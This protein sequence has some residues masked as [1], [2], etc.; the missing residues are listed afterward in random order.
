MRHLPAVFMCFTVLSRLLFWAFAQFTW[1]DALI[2][3]RYAENIF[4]GN[5][6]VYNLGEKVLGTT[7]PLYTFWLVLL[8]FL[9]GRFFMIF[10][11]LSNIQMDGITIFFLTKLLIEKFK[12]TT[13]ALF[14]TLLVSINPLLNAVAISGMEMSFLIMLMTLSIYSMYYEKYTLTGVLLGLILLTRMDGAIFLILI[15]VHTYLNCKKNSFRIFCAFILTVIPF[16]G[17]E[18]FYFGSIIPNS[19]IAKRALFNR[20]I[21]EMIKN[22]FDVYSDNI[23][24]FNVLIPFG[25]YFIL[26]AYKTLTFIVIF[27]LLYLCFLTL[28]RVYLFEWYFAPGVFIHLLISAIGIQGVMDLSIFH[29]KVHYLIAAVFVLVIGLMPVITKIEWENRLQTYEM[30]VRENIGNWLKVNTAE[31]ATI[32]LEPIGYIGY[33]SN[34]YIYDAVGLVSPEV[35]K[36][37][38]EHPHDWLYYMILKFNP[39]YLVTRE[40]FQEPVLR[41]SQ[42]QTDEILQ[43]YIVIKHFPSTTDYF[44]GM[45]ILSRRNLHHQ[46]LLDD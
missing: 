14:F 11:K 34:R 3:L 22:V 8:K 5:G 31:K 38:L 43:R 16:L 15:L 36:I 2:T 39:D 18:Y 46:E 40:N 41:L 1:E 28:T 37:R 25:I 7:T 45:Q 44:P 26:T 13:A 35:I 17:L 29:R 33:Y 20:A 42:I 19:I 9:A 6:F 4:Q 32:L 30:N 24:I 27:D 21:L 23:S 10:W 12:L